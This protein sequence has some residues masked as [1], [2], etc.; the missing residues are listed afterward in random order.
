MAS[1]ASTTLDHF[2]DGSRPTPPRDR[3]PGDNVE[4]VDARSGLTDCGLPGTPYSLNPYLGCTHGCRY[5]YVP[6]VTHREQAPWGGWVKAKR[7]LPRLLSREVRRRDPG[8]VFLSS[9]TDPYQPAEGRY[10]LTRRC[11]EVLLRVQWPLRVLT[12]SPLVLRDLDLL[13]GFDDLRV[14]VS[15]PTLDDGF[16]QA[17]EPQA[18]P[19]AGR[20]RALERIHAAGIPT[21]AS[22]APTYP[23][24]DGWAPANVADRVAATGVDRVFFGQWNYREKAQP[25]T[26]RA[27]RGTPYEGFGEEIFDEDATA[28]RIHHLAEAFK[29]RGVRVGVPD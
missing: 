8:L 9:A 23:L 11:L 10:E 17:V 29:V 25:A 19:V 18:P 15:V 6:S 20:L 26:L 2:R 4:E 7:N 24:T 12:R 22:L 28:E 1:P 16:R 27:L 5:C 21:Y 14:G 13:E 3:T